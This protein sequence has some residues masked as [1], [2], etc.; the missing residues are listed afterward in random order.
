MIAAGSFAQFVSRRRYGSN[1]S[2]T[3]CP[4]FLDTNAYRRVLVVP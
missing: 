3:D 2:S 4:G 1:H